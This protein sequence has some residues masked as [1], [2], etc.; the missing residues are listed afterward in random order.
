[1]RVTGVLATHF[2]PDHVGGDLM[3]YRIEGITDLLERVHV[4]VHVQRD[5]APWVVRATGVGE[6]ELAQ[7][8]SG[9]V[10]SVGDVEIE[11]VHTPGHTPG[12]QC[13]SVDGRLVS[14]DT[15]FLDGC[16]RTDLPGGDPEQ[17]YES[18]TTRLARFGDD[19]VLYPG[20]SL[21][22]GALGHHGRHPCPQ[23]RVPP[24]HARAVAGHVRRLTAMRYLEPGRPR[25]RRPSSSSARPSPECGRS[26]PC[27][28]RA[29]AAAS[30]LVGDEPH[31]PYDRP[32]LSK[33][34]LAG[35]W[36]LE[37]VRL[38]DAAED[39]RASGLDLRLGR[40]A[41]ALDVDAHNVELDDGATVEFDGLVVATGAHA[42]PLPGTEAVAGV[43]TLR[44]LED[45][46]TLAP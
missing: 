2:H 21:C 41:V 20:P 10:V 11:L 25:R 36:G 4:P 3:G 30:I 27:V 26:R 37:R 19:T 5:E 35:T 14:G 42:R 15:L 8:S 16:G 13:F 32:P 28:P 22:P 6:D 24:A 17:M 44:T 12:S 46:L 43:Q 38:R 9:D 40:R 7:H 18:I 34:F 33:Q 39:R 31:L 45:C 29:T 23:L 1:M